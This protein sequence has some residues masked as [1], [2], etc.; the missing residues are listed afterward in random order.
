MICTSH[1][2][3]TVAATVDTLVFR[4]TVE[5]ARGSAV[6]VSANTQT[7]TFSRQVT[8]AS[9]SSLDFSGSTDVL[10]FPM[11][12]YTAGTATVESDSPN[13]IAVAT[14]MTW[15][16]FPA[17]GQSLARVT[18][19]DV[20]LLEIDTQSLM[21]TAAVADLVVPTNISAD[22]YVTGSDAGVSLRADPICYTARYFQV[23][24]DASMTE[25]HAT[26]HGRMTPNG[27][28]NDDR[29]NTSP[30]TCGADGLRYDDWITDAWPVEHDGQRPS[31]Q[32]PFGVG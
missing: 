14:D 20:G 12:L 27:E 16:V 4:E 19:N 15:Y 28:K 32:G 24:F 29:C 25:N 8:A 1:A 2:T 11:G 30:A 23:T 3:L 7:T 22:E 5:M 6:S 13:S 26:D 9:D 17:S 21:G 10:A 18:F 31:C